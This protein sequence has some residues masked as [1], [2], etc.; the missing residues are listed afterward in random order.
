MKKLNLW[1]TLF[2]MTMVLGTFTAC[3]NDDSDDNGALPEITVDGGSAVAVARDLTAGLTSPVVTVVSNADWKISYS[4][5]GATWCTPK[6]QEGTLGKKGTV[7]LVFD[8]GATTSARETTVTLTASGS[9]QGIPINPK[10]TINVKQNAGGSTSAETNVAAVRTALKAIATT[11]AAPITEDLTLT[12]IV[13][14]DVAAG[15]TAGNRNC[16]LVDNSTK[17][18]AGIMVRFNAEYKFPVGQVITASIKGS[19]VALSYGMLQITPSA[20]NIFSAVTGAVETVAP[21]EV[22]NLD[23]L[24]KYEAQYVKV[25][26]VQPVAADRGGMYYSGTASYK[27]TNF[28][29]ENGSGLQISIYKTNTWATTTA[30]PAKSGFICGI[31]TIFNGVGQVAPRNASDVAGLTEE[32]FKV[33]TTSTTIGSITE[34]GTY[35]VKNATVVA[36]GATAYAIADNTGAMLVY[37]K[38]NTRK[39]GE[40]INI[41]GAVTIYNAT[42]TPQFSEAAAVTVVSEGN[43]WTYNPTTYTAT[44]VDA[45]PSNI[46]F[47]E[48][49]IAGKLIKSGNYYNLTIAGT[50][51]EGSIQYYTPDAAVLDRNVVIKG[52]AC[53]TSKSGEITRIKIFPYEITTSSDP[54][55]SATDTSV[56]FVAGGEA[57]VI[58]YTAGNLGSN[59]LY[60]KIAGDG[61]AQ[62]SITTAPADNKLTVTAIA[63]TATSAKTATLTIYAAP[64]ADGTAVVSDVVTLTQVAP[65]AEGSQTITMTV[66]SVTGFP[67]AE[68]DLKTVTI[69]S[70]D[71]FVYKGYKGATANYLMLK[72]SSNAYLGTPIV[73]GVAL[74]SITITTGSSAST[75]ATAQIVDENGTV[76]G[77]Q[78][79]LNKQG[80]DFTFELTGTTAGKSYRILATG[81]KNTQ[82]TKAVLKYE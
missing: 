52:Y 12:G 9:F 51:I 35:E 17:E 79:T 54:Y 58:N 74:K 66:A 76:V 78:Q 18:G 68:S 13:I 70:Y 2:C 61:A 16:Y 53:G 77:A 57:K 37:H 40:K 64:A 71:W 39:V 14:S 4:G 29:T 50:A 31:V 38:D 5:D 1:K 36:V 48:I 82:V 63:N 26:K 81:S 72:G 59:N 19:S 56:S 47:V 25:P 22:S 33:T 44:Q 73:S 41:S 23:D 43:K 45:Y 62:F 46:K 24:V 11:T 49:S 80:A 8:L 15:G 27:T 10:V 21:V 42:S 60:A 75:S 30:V 6:A 28:E 20:D 65:A 69:D 32:L 55:L 34:A 3:S 7:K 67:T